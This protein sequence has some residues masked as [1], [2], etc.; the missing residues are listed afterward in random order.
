MHNDIDIDIAIARR[1]AAFS[2]APC[3]F[4][5]AASALFLGVAALL[6]WPAPEI[7]F[8]TDDSPAAWLSSAQL[9]GMALVSLRLFQERVLSRGLCLWLGAAMVTM[10]F[11]EQFMLHEHWKYA[12]IGWLD[13]CRHAWVMEAP[14]LL[15]GALGLATL[16]WLHRHLAAR[17]ARIVLWLAVG[18]GLFALV[19][20][21]T[22]QPVGLLP[23]KAALLVLAESLFAG[24]LLGIGGRAD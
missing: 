14:M 4:L 22:Q 15:V 23:Y 1:A 3:F 18:V 21:F 17:G 6:Y 12:C 7:A 9:W 2:L 24:V 11:D 5:L 20:R 8:R 16:A 13:A 19:L 10:S